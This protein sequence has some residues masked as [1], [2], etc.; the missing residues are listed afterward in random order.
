MVH[1][2][3]GVLFLVQTPACILLLELCE[4]NFV[5]EGSTGVVCSAEQCLSSTLYHG[6]GLEQYRKGFVV[7]NSTGRLE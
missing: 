5:L 1:K 4:A 2:S 3:A 7:Q 6:E